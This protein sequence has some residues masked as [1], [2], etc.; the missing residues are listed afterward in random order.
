MSGDVTHMIGIYDAG[1]ELDEELAIGASTG[2]QQ[3]M[4]DFGAPDPIRQVRAVGSRYPAPAS[5]HLRVTL[6]PR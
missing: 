2:P 4:P 5:T 1:T 3:P 6:T